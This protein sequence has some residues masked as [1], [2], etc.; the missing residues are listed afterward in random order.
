MSLLDD[1]SDKLLLE[2]QMHSA[3]SLKN[4]WFSSGAV[5]AIKSKSRRRRALPEKYRN[6][7]KNPRVVRVRRVE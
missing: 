4:K 5:A 7:E 3:G 6:D 1:S 2:V